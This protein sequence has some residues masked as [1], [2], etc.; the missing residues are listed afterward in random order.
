MK[1]ALIILLSFYCLAG[2][3]QITDDFSDGNFSS[4]PQWNGSNT[5]G[6]FK[7][8]NNRLR[9]E[10]TKIS[11]NFYLSTANNLAK[12]CYWEFWINLQF[13]TSGSNY[14]DVYLVSDKS[15]LQ[16]TLINGYFVRIGNTEDE[17]S[18]YKRS[19]SAGSSTRIIDGINASVGST[20]NTIKVRVSR[21]NLGL[22][23]LEREVIGT[24]SQLVNE[25]SFLDSS[26][27]NTSSFGIF[28]QQSTASFFQ[29]HFFDDFKIGT[30]NTDTIAPLLSTITV[31]DSITLELQFSEAMDSLSVKDKKNYSIQNFQGNILIINTETNPQKYKIRLSESLNTGSYTLTAINVMDRSG[32]KIKLNNTHSFNYIKPYYGIFRDIVMNEIFPDPSPQVDLPMAEFVELL[33]TSDITISIKNWK[34]FDLTSTAIIGDYSISPGSNVILCAKPDTSEFQ[35]YGR[36]IGISPWPSLNNSN[37]VIKLA[38]TQSILIDSVSYS[39]IW[40]RNTEK[41]QGGWSLERIDPK[42]VCGGLFNWTASTDSTGG[43]PGKRNSVHILDYDLLPLKA[44]SLNKIT[45]TTLIV[46]LNKHIDKSTILKENFRLTPDAG[47]I[48]TI[49]PDPEHKQLIITF[50]KLFLAGTSYNLTIAGL[51]DCSGNRIDNKFS[52]LKFSIPVPSP[53][54]VQKPDT[55]SMYITEIFADP[56]PEVGLPLVE[57]IEIYNPG[58]DSVNLEDWTLTDTQT[59]SALKQTI[60]GAG[61]YLILCPAADTSQ[62]K[63]FGKTMGLSPWPTLGN[64]SDR[65]VLKSFKNRT[66]DSISYSDKWYKDNIKKSG[67]WSLEKINLTQIICRDFYN[68]VASTDKTGGTPG[69][70]NSI[71]KPGKM[72]LEARIASI[73]VL[74]DSTLNIAFDQVPDTN[75]LK[76]S[77]FNIPKEIG[78]AKTIEVNANFLGITLSFSQ[79]FKEGTAYLLIA[80]SLYSC[81]G[82]LSSDMNKQINFNIPS[83]PENQYPL[84]INEIFADP[85]PSIGL[86]D[87]EFVELYNP[88]SSPVKLS[89]LNFGDQSRN[90]SLTN[91]EIAAGSYLILCAQKD[92]SLYSSYGKVIGIP[93]WPDLNNENDILILR[94]NKGKEIHKVRYSSNWYQDSEK[95]KGGYTLELIDPES[96]C[97]GSQNWK[98]STDNSGGTPGRMNSWYQTNFKSD[99]LKLIEIEVLDSLK[100]LVTFNK[101]VDSV[102]A[103]S[104]SNYFINNG[105]G[106][107]NKS[108]IIEPDFNQILLTLKEPFSKGQTY[109]LTTNTISD[110]KNGTIPA[111]FNTMEFNISRDIGKNDILITEILFNPRPE[112]SDFV[113]ILNNSEHVL[114]LKDLYI[115]R[116]TKDSI[117]STQQLSKKQL[118][119]D[120]GNYLALSPDPDNIKKEYTLKNAASIL[121]IN[122]FPS[123]NDDAGTVVLISNGQIIDRLSYSEKMH[124]QLLKTKEGISLE[125]SKLNRPNDDPGNLRSA[126]SA[127]GFATPGY[128]NSQHSENPFFQENLTFA[129]K[130]FSPDNDGFEDLLEINYQFPEPGKIANVSI[131]NVHGMLIKRLLK[132][133]TLN[134]EGSFVWDGFNE[135]NQLVPG[136]IYL[137]QADIYDNDG[138]ISKFTK[139][140]VLAVKL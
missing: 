76:A 86:P 30:L 34:I 26:H 101:T 49:I 124:F 7:I 57:F 106:N 13:S 1:N 63:P 24:N 53:P 125:R 19:G 90:Y 78:G 113:E 37:D 64:T 103:S 140:F 42:S 109:R 108:Q 110:C 71:D 93:L 36:V 117:N 94:N 55:A 56:S 15:D 89:G 18:L 38:N 17:I 130:T 98:A 126:T 72:N 88:T 75:Y 129:S 45:D 4:N 80:D 54:P 102:K 40:Y 84:I 136:G 119:I 96:I 47:N 131:Y 25:G 32:N 31:L 60:I 6:D 95:R 92:T 87:S 41:K 118:L 91:G 5:G 61:E 128:K 48:R 59:K 100:I 107:P 68:W 81:S 12:N 23:T 28:I 123:F 133:Y 104:N 51:R 27:V 97:I 43:T 22:F 50:T 39:D 67:G 70:K 77:N 82:K 114:D 115:A 137:L 66:V 122:P 46:Y 138:Q 33:N 120:P 62:Y 58:K 135:H 139:S 16:S 85:A 116:I 2:Y 8:V 112:G 99:V 83:I 74:S 79:K 10:S 73:I 3:T 132:N 29:K 35:K 65:L 134:L 21:D 69:R 121:K 9:S 52:Q 111:E 127:S 14:V 44:D 105:V 11:G 20:N